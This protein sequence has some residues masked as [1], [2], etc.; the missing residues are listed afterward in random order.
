MG[1]TGYIYCIENAINRK[2]YIGQTSSSVGKRFADHLRCARQYTQDCPILYRAM[3]K[4][5]IENFSVSVVDTVFASSHSELKAMLNDLEVFYIAKFGT[6]TPKGYNMTTGGY[7]FSDHV[8]VPVAQVLAD[9]NVIAVYDSIKD[10]EIAMNIP[11]G[12]IKRALHGESHY[13]NEYF[14]YDNS[15]GQYCVGDNVGV[16]HRADI[17]PVYQFD[18]CGNFV[19]SYVSIKDAESQTGI[20]HSH[21]SSACSMKRKSAGGF[22]WSYTPNAAPYSSAQKTHKCRAVLQMNMDGSPVRSYPSATQAAE[23]LGLFQTLISKCCNGQ[24]KSTGGYRW[25]FL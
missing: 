15:A 20:S 7:S 1:Y 3:H 22:V 16:Q 10:A 5:G 8:V 12:S 23:E 25:A 21:I 6:Y 24:R 11:L 4:Y 19:G 9:G 17:T 18:L 13:A 2:K 14:W